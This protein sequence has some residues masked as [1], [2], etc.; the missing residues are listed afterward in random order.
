MD[1]LEVRPL[2]RLCG[3][4]SRLGQVDPVVLR[5][6]GRCGS[7]RHR[8][9]AIGIRHEVGGLP[10][11]RWRVEGGVLCPP[12]RAELAV[13]NHGGVVACGGGLI[14]LG[15]VVEGLRIGAPGGGAH[16]RIAVAVEALPDTRRRIRHAAVGL[17]GTRGN[18]HNR[19]ETPQQGE[20]PRDRD[21]GCMSLLDRGLHRGSP[22]GHVTHAVAWIAAMTVRLAIWFPSMP[23]QIAFPRLCTESCSYLDTH[24]SRH[25]NVDTHDSTSCG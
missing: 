17:S 13:G 12:G 2:H 5:R 20:N 21:G 23:L 8:V 1:Q 25:L 4:E 3:V 10:G 14:D 6:V 11:Q 19:Q 15:P 18:A 16:R 9:L 22:P 7:P 24:I